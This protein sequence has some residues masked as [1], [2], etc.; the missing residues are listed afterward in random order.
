MHE[1]EFEKTV[2][3]RMEELSFQPSAP[4]WE[5]VAAAI[6]TRKRRRAIFWILPLLLLAGGAWFWYH[7][8]ESEISGTALPATSGPAP[9]EIKKEMHISEKGDISLNTGKRKNQ[10]HSNTPK[11][12]QEETGFSKK[13]PTDITPRTK[14]QAAAIAAKQTKREQGVFSIEKEIETP[15]GEIVSDFDGGKSLEPVNGILFERTDYLLKINP[16]IPFDLSV[17]VPKIVAPAKKLQWGVDLAWGR[18]NLT[19]KGLRTDAFFQDRFNSPG[20]SPVPVTGSAGNVV[21]PQLPTTAGFFFSSGLQ[22]VKPMRG[23]WSLKSGLQ[24]SLYTQR[25]G[26]GEKVNAAAINGNISAAALRSRSLYRSSGTTQYIASRFHQGSLP[27]SL[28]YKPIKRLPLEVSTGIAAA[29]I[30]GGRQIGYDTVSRLFFETRPAL[31][32]FQWVGNAG[33]HYRVAKG[34]KWQWLASAQVQYHLS[35]LYAAPGQQ[36]RLSA[37]SAG[38]GIR[39]R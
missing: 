36:A 23:R 21:I 24:Y 17:P 27:I 26:V 10:Q 5:N 29:Y 18:A 22:I 1:Q 7:S 37:I 8:N 6:Q 39:R 12:I 32:S 19:E 35:G 13:I 14:K 9:E 20:Q 31:N 34:A 2:Q 25:L 11:A 28:H 3:N 38:L 30:S 4:V 16:A 33:V 15:S